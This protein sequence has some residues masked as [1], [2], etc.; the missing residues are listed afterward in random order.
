MRLSIPALGLL[1]VLLS[2]PAALAAPTCQ[3]RAGGTIRCGAEGA[4]PA[5]WSLPDSEREAP[6]PTD[7]L[8]MWEAIA[9]VAMLLALIAIMPEFDGRSDADWDRQEGDDER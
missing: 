5:G 9:M 1:I 4:M 8:A 3:D 7:T 6:P 2:A